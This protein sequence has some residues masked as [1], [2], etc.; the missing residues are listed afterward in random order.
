MREATKGLLPLMVVLAIPIIPFVIWG[1]PLERG[2][3]EWLDQPGS[4]GSV[5]GGLMTL[6]AVDIFLPVPSSLV[7]TVG[8]WRLGWALGTLVSFLGMSLGAVFG[9]SLARRWGFPLAARLSPPEQLQRMSE[10]NQRF[11]SVLLILCRPI[12]VVA[13]ASVLWTGM[14][15]MTWR[16]FLPPVLLSNLAI[17]F[18]YS[19]FGHWAADHQWLPWA[20][21]A[22][23]ALPLLMATMWGRLWK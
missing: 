18:V 14:N 3:R 4:T 17:S 19:A 23:V 11:G 10:F 2:A 9:F 15:Q 7:S 13:E 12:P 16:R 6:H 1:E 8:G 20:L 5:A 21:V 22:S